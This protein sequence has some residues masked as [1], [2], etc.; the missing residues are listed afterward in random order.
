MKK[1]EFE[2]VKVIFKKYVLK[3]IDK[4][5][6]NTRFFVY[7]ALIKCDKY[8]K[9]IIDFVKY[10]EKNNFHFNEISSTLIHDIKGIS[11]NDNFFIPRVF[12]Y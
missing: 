2:Q 4:R 11:K 8:Y 9:N 12:N 7:D 3:H 5:N 10:A 1:T 6:L